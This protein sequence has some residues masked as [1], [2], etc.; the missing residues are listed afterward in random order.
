MWAGYRCLCLHDSGNSFLPEGRVDA[1][2]HACL[3]FICALALA[4]RRR[5]D[6]RALIV[7]DVAARGLDLPDCDAVINLELPSDAAHYAHRAGR[8]GRAGRRAC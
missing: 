5:G 1:S 7:S 8:T 2:D 4:T 6:Y 3:Y